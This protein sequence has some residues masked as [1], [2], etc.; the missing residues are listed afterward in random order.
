MEDLTTT[1][2]DRVDLERIVALREFEAFARLAMDPGA[3][4]YVAGGAWDELSLADNEAAWRRFRLRP[5]VLVDVSRIDATS[6]LLGR[7]ASMPVAIAP[8][9]VHG[10]AHPDGEVATAR[11]AA[12]AGV[13]FALS[14][15]SSRS[16]EEVAERAP[17]GR[18]WFQL[19]VQ[20][21]PGR[22]RELVERAAAAGYEALMLTVDL[23]RLGYRERDRRSGWELPPLG[24]FSAAAPA[25]HAQ[26]VHAHGFDML[27]AQHEVGLTWDDVATIRSWSSMAFVLKG[28]LTEEDARLAVDHGVDAIVVSN[29]GARQLDRV[30]A[31]I[32]VLER[33]VEAVDGRTEVWVDGGVRRGIDVVIARALGAQGVLLGRPVLWALATEGEAGVAR[34]LTI[35][36]EEFEVALTLLGAPTADAITRGHVERPASLRSEG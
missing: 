3:F 15:T 1:R 11:A 35:L 23:P 27:E 2:H 33:I 14:T 13:P 22:S 18:R 32:D 26:R 30:P 25:T 29:H 4:D 12:G 28:I 8:M 5:R 20:L 7:P 31:P 19:Y 24:N 34:A 6:T 21:D 16:I 10:V 9:A 36:R 17:D